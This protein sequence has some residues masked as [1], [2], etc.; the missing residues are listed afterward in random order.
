MGS[1]ADSNPTEYAPYTRQIPDAITVP[2]GNEI[3]FGGGY[4]GI[5]AFGVGEN[6]E[7]PIFTQDIPHTPVYT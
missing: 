6:L 2:I 3:A 4:F 7:A 5:G 1:T